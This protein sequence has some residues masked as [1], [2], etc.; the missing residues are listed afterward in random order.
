MKD[1]GTKS[2]PRT[3]P[4][5][6]L[7]VRIHPLFP[8]KKQIVFAG[9]TS[10]FRVESDHANERGAHDGNATSIAADLPHGE[11]PADEE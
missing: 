6:L 9:K 10:V 11:G 4:E 8:I 2:A 7:V 5:I 3:H 1:S